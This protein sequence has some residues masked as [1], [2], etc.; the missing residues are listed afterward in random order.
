MV[1]CVVQCEL[2][3]YRT[4]Q[5]DMVKAERCHTNGGGGVVGRYASDT[6]YSSP[7]WTH[8]D[9]VVVSATLCCGDSW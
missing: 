7:E 9:V 5:R 3:K 2:G 6:Q 4:P 8:T 1:H